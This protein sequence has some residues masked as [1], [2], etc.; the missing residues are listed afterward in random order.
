M[1]KIISENGRSLLETLAVLVIIAIILLASVLGYDFVLHQ[2]KKQ[3][4][5][6]QVS[7]LFVRYELRP[8]KPEDGSNKVAIKAVYPEVDRAN[9]VTMKTADAGTSYLITSSTTDSFAVVM[10]RVLADSC[11]TQLERGEYGGVLL[12]N[13]E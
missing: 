7:E 1:R 10:D 5:V 4:T 2:W 13:Q 3:Q 9:A 8:V 11:E 12:S 6:K